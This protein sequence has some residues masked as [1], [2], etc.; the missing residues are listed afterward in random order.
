MGWLSKGN[1]EILPLNTQNTSFPLIH[2]VDTEKGIALTGGT[3][4]SYRQVLSM[5]RMDAE[6]RLQKLRFFLFEGTSGGTGKFP[7]KH[8]SS[9]ITQIQ[10]LKGALATIGSEEVLAKAARLEEAGKDMDLALIQESLPEF[11]EQ[12]SALVKNIKTAIE[13]TSDKNEAKAGT[14]RSFI[15]LFGKQK[16]D[17]SPSLKS[18]YSEYLSVFDELKKALKLQNVT[19]IEKNLDILNQK[20]TEPKTKEILEH[21]SDQ[22]LMTEF[23]SAIKTIDELLGKN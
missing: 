18:D 5:F 4:D 1:R 8:L 22:V 3:T 13:Q 12:L 7:G 2:G 21:I 16:Q 14:S 9:L 6:E 10:A 19:D 11:I 23:D 15:Q 17:K 20:I